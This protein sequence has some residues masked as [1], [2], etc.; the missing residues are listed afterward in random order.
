MPPFYRANLQCILLTKS[1]PHGGLREV[2]KNGEFT[3]PG[4]GELMKQKRMA[5]LGHNPKTGGGI[6]IAAKTVVKVQ[7]AKAAKVSCWWRN[8]EAF[9]RVCC[10]KAG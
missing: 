10:L 4:I 9:P 1:T 3:F 2:K 7:V 6:K 5:R 8:K